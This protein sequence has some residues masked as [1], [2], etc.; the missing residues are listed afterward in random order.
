[1][2]SYRKIH[3]QFITCCVYS[4]SAKVVLTGSE[5]SEIKIWSLNGGYIDTFRGHAKS[6]TNL[7]LNPYNSNLVLSSSLDGF[8]KMWSLDVM[9]CIYEY[10][11]RKY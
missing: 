6:V 4:P 10:D 11:L 2:R 1:M 9:Q 7:I 5:D 8:V 3:A